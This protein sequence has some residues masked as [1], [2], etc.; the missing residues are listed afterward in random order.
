MPLS[1]SPFEYPNICS[2]CYWSINDEQR[3][4]ELI[5]LIALGH[6]RH[7]ERI[8][9]ATSGA[10][11][12]QQSA[13]AKRSAKRLLTVDASSDP[14]HRDGWIFQAMSWIAARRADPAAYLRTPH[15]ILAHKGF[16]GL[17]VTLDKSKKK[18]LAA[19]VF[20][21]KATENPRSTIR[22]DVWPEFE[23]LESGDRENVLTADLVSVLS[24]I[25]GCDVDSAIQSIVWSRTRHFR[26]SIT[27]GESHQDDDGRKKLF[28]GFDAV[29][30]GP[31]AR[32][33]AETVFIPDLRNWM[34][35]LAGKAISYIDRT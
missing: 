32:R 12:I 18:V 16:D 30:T 28:K 20:E 15:T 34:D 24:S 9:A 14:W 1:L 7:V 4:A 5:A 33:R 3:L 17:S 29:V 22:D 10:S 8:V 25:Q 35:S 19:I 26:V 23:A 2:G 11:A 21:D 27:A 31:L 13:G 6:A